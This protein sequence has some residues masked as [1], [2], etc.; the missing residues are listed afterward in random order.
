MT[1][2]QENTAIQEDRNGNQPLVSLGLPVFNGE[3][4]V[5]EAIESVLEQTYR[6]FELIIIDNASEDR[7]LEICQ[8]FVARDKRIHLV[9]NP[10]NRGAIYSFNKT[11]TLSKGK[12]FK[13]VAHDDV[14]R[15]EFLEKCVARL[16]AKPSA[17]MCFTK[18]RI[19]DSA[20]NIRTDFDDFMERADSPL[21]HER[22]K[23]VIRQDYWCYDIFGLIRSDVLKETDLFETYVGSDRM[24][25][26][27]LVL[28][29]E[30]LE[31]P[32]YLFLSRDHPERSVRAMPSHHQRV[33]W[34]SPDTK[35]RFTLPHWRFF[36]EYYRLISRSGLS[37][38]EILSCR[39]TLLAWVGRNK[40][41][42][43][44]IADLV[45]AVWPSSWKYFYRFGGVDKFERQVLDS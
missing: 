10:R 7:T 9:Q 36:V 38:R 31:V 25:R 8:E 5:S 1:E 18:L 14:I 19:M 34:F 2:H 41:W 21:P 39:L 15:P 16:E 30:F 32:E 13:W 6:N 17:S 26:A 43:K 35:S 20:G 12:Y 42:A 24:L 3:N 27:E 22:F 11:F 37:R 29:G 45:I 33:K 40:T 23:A 28:R 44:M 4:Y